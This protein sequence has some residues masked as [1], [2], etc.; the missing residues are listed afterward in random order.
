MLFSFQV[1]NSSY[2]CSEYLAT[3][4]ATYS[5]STQTSNIWIVPKR[6][7]YESHASIG[8]YSNYFRTR[9]KPNGLCNTDRVTS[10]WGRYWT[11]KNREGFQTSTVRAVVHAA[12]CQPRTAEHRVQPRVSPCGICCGHSCTSANTCSLLSASFHQCSTLPVI[13]N[14]VI[15]RTSRKSMGTMKQSY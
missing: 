3:P 15:R 10:L 14:T 12:S 1:Q 7:I 5:N 9:H 11:W 4:P 2:G 6:R 13:N 8:I